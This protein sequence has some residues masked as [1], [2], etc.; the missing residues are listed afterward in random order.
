MFPPHHRVVLSTIGGVRHCDGQW[1][2]GSLSLWGACIAARWIHFLRSLVEGSEWN[3]L[4]GCPFWNKKHI[5]TTGLLGS[6]C[7]KI[8]GKWLSPLNQSSAIRVHNRWL[9][10][11][12]GSPFLKSLPERQAQ[13]RQGG[14]FPSAL[15]W[16]DAKIPYSI[17]CSS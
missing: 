6:E 15:R 2:G 10:P 3:P 16:V 7:H 14:D 9:L 13:N 12:I 5:E 17:N 1:Q 8:H 11:R 4:V